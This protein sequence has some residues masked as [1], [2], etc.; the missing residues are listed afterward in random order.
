MFKLTNLF[1]N[2]VN[3]SKDEIAAFL[4]TD[5]KALEAFE[6]AYNA[7]TIN[8]GVSDNL[9]K[10]NGKQVA[11]MNAGIRLDTPESLD[12]FKQRIV[13]ELI[14][15]TVVYSYH[16][17]KSEVIDLQK[18]VPDNELVTSVDIMSLPEEFRPS[19]TGSLMKVDIPGTGMHLLNLLKESM[20]HKKLA[21]QKANYHAFRQ[22]LDILDVDALTYEIIDRNVNSMGYWIPRMAG[23]INEEGFFKI[24]NTKIIKVPLTILQLTRQDYMSLSKTTLNIVDDYCRKVF[25][26]KEDKDYFI[27]TGTYSSKYDFRNARVR[28]AKEI[29]ELGEY[30]LFI[31]WQA[32]QMAHY[33]L[34]GRKQ[35][36]IY[37]V[38]TTTEWVVRDFI[39][40]V[41]NNPCIYHGMPLHTEYR[42]FV[43]F[44]TDTVLGI[45]PY[46]DKDVMKKHFDGQEDADSKHDYI[47][48]SLA[49]KNLYKRYE[50]NKNSVIEHLSLVIPNVEMH[51]QWSVDIMQ[52]GDDF[53]FIDMAVAENSAFYAESVPV[54]LRNPMKENWIPDLTK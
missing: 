52:N 26:L 47:A 8:E 36:I 50:E 24:P 51:G 32:L 34:S 35:P 46:W 53:Y 10:I 28:G 23:A 15:K 18:K 27:K 2:K 25:E 30:L 37:G 21:N 20:M 54:E 9:F 33:N 29:R 39:E 1:G 49:E 40:D 13:N 44:D 38:S 41:E 4:K 17:G 22:G 5:T 48:Y 42:A 3:V 16:N 14:S 7:H 45:H 19:L 31:H 43:D 11:E 6:E 12:S